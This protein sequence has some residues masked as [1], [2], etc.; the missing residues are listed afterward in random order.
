ME[1]RELELRKQIQA[2]EKEQAGQQA[3]MTVSF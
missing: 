2:M 3:G 1:Q